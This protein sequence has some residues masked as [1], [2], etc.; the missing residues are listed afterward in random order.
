MDFLAYGPVSYAMPVAPVWVLSSL[1]LCPPCPR[2]WSHPPR[3]R[4]TGWLPAGPHLLCVPGK[5]T[6][7][8]AVVIVSQGIHVTP[9]KLY[10]LNIYG[11]LLMSI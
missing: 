10:S 3:G 1:I 8:L 5:R 2:P 6:L 9:S 11:I 7:F 4:G